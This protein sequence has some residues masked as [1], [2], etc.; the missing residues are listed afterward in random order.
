MATLSFTIAE[1]LRQLLTLVFGTAMILYLTPKLA[2][3]MLLTF[4]VLVVV[5]LMSFALI[6]VVP[7]DVLDVMYAD[8]PLSAAQI[9]DIRVQ[10]G[11]GG[12]KLL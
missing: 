2:G 11:M 4:P 3:F 10:L 8:S 1:M 9:Q 7:G 12:H 6:R 5:S